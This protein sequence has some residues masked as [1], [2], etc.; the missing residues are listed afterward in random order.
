V[1]PA[2]VVVTPVSDLSLEMR[3]RLEHEQGDHCVTRPRT[4][5]FSSV[6]DAQTA[7]LL[8]QFRTPA[9]IVDAVMG[10]CTAQALDPEETLDAAFNALSMLVEEGLLVPETSRL[11]RPIAASLP[12]GLLID[13]VE[14][15]E[16]A[17]LLDDTEVYRARTSAGRVVA[18]KIAGASAGPQAIAAIH[19]EAAVLRRLDGTVNP[20]LVRTGC[21]EDR[22]FLVTAWHAGVDLY[23]AAANLRGTLAPDA[24][25]EILEI[26]ERILEAYA[27]L[28]DQGILHGDI[29]PRNVLVDAAG[30]VTVID[31][32]LAA[33]PDAGIADMRGGID[34]FHAP[35]IA[36]SRLMSAE[37][38]APSFA[39][40]QYSL[41]ALLYLLLTGGHTHAFSMQQEEMLRQVVEDPPMPFSR[42][43]I[44][45]LVAVE[46][47]VQRGLA[48]EPADRYQSVADF[49]QAFHGGAARD[50]ASRPTVSSRSGAR[51][52]PAQEFL[53]EVLARIDVPGELF[54]QGLEPPT[55]SV[56]YGGAGIAYALLRIARARGD[57]KLLAHAD[58]WATRAALSVSKD[59][60]FWNRGLDIVPETF[61]R[62]SLFHHASGVHCVE[63]LVAHGR[64]DERAQLL[65]VERFIAASQDCDRMDIAFGR[66]G[67]LVGCAILLEALPSHLDS[68][69]L[70]SFGQSLLQ[71]ITFELRTEPS[72]EESEPAAILGISHGWSGY[73]F[74]ILYWCEASDTAPPAEVR[75]RLE[76]LATM[77][78]PFGRGVRWPRR[79]GESVEDALLAASWCNGAAGYVH[80]WSLAHRYWDD[81]RYD[82]LAEQA[83]WTAYE[84][85]DDAPGGLCCGL[86]G[87]A[88]AL[89]SRYKHTAEPRWLTR[90]RLLGERAANRNAVQAHRRNS[91]YHGEVGIA[92]LA[93]DLQ[94]P[95]TASM[96]LFEAEGWPHSGGKGCRG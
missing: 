49:L 56:T 28:H 14:I 43:D 34:L 27:R 65:A 69:P 79:A 53:D 76:E 32:G 40:E 35:E 70:R 10:L 12:S 63:S 21:F 71:S 57:E 81:G 11:A 33:V 55:A 51:Q 13:G 78:Q 6:V 92:L 93:A 90:A 46:S 67:L 48:K 66:S 39:S 60:A 50:Y 37:V 25:K 84:S 72:L 30:R 87:R 91:L 8:E 18:L 58:I 64:G 85:A 52:D 2:D 80:L 77:A 31:Y 23:R 5:T 20:C 7:A 68:S 73:L 26:A 61:G 4:R 19:N 45:D 74:A 86:A 44:T 16:P 36:R 88:Y 95:A 29:Q 1:L 47:C 38:P 22:P 42:Y 9:T 24:R 15:V 62:V 75:E 41:A 83:A 54:S 89:L 59:E 17:H 82:Q 96:P 3:G 94:A